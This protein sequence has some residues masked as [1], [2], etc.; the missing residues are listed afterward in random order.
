[1]QASLE[2]RDIQVPFLATLAVA[3]RD[4]YGDYEDDPGGYG[5]LRLKLRAYV[6]GT[7][8]GEVVVES[9][10]VATAIFAVGA[11]G[12][13]GTRALES[14]SDTMCDV[15][16]ASLYKYSIVPTSNDIREPKNMHKLHIFSP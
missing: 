1:M 10:E 11:R 6:C 7:R 14:V 12:C 15:C 2:T 8:V 16:N 5:H 3:L 4:F 9:G 13:P